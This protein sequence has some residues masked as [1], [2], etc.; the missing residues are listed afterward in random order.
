MSASTSKECW[1]VS[2]FC[3]IKLI[4]RV[5]KNFTQIYIKGSFA[6]IMSA[7]HV[8]NASFLIEITQRRKKVSNKLWHKKNN[9]GNLGDGHVRREAEK[10][11]RKCVGGCVHA[12]GPWWRWARAARG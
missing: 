6:S 11:L 3:Q 7:L 10:Q 9:F 2:I 12:L 1:F 4:V 8:Y 5:A